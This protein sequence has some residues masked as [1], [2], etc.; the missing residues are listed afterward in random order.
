MQRTAE[1]PPAFPD[2]AAEQW[3]IGWHNWWERHALQAAREGGLVPNL[4]VRRWRDLIELSWGD[5]PIAGTPEGFTFGAVHGCA[6]LAPGDVADVL[7]GILDDASHHL[8]NELST[9]PAFAHLRDDV[10]RLRETDC[11]RRLGLL[12]GLRSDDLQPEDRWSHIESLFPANLPSEI[13]DAIFGVEADDLV[14][15]SASQAAL[16]FGSLS[17]SIDAADARAWLR[18]SFSSTTRVVRVAI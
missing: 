4:F 11:R 17:P 1:P 12:S 5:R 8:L 13:G 15:K 16:M 2:D 10:V 18:S 7:Y 14:I 3:E 9:S 6:Q